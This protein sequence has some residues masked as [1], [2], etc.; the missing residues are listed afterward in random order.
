VLDDADTGLFRAGI[1]GFS[2]LI[3][4]NPGDNGGNKGSRGS[5]TTDR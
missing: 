5:S 3:D 1:S 4:K 2:A